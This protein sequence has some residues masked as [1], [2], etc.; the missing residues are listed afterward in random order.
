MFFEQKNAWQVGRFQNMVPGLPSQRV[1]NI[2]ATQ[3]YWNKLR[4]HAEQESDHNHQSLVLLF[5][6]TKFYASFSHKVKKICHSFQVRNL[7]KQD[8]GQIEPF[9]TSAELHYNWSSFVLLEDVPHSVL[10]ANKYVA[11]SPLWKHGAR[12]PLAKSDSLFEPQ[13]KTVCNSP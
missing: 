10:W 7:S 9:A 1:M 12:N 2:E 4:K 3:G 6:C 5:N 11:S 8:K 13:N